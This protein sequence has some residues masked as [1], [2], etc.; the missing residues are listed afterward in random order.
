MGSVRAVDAHCEIHFGGEPEYWNFSDRP[1]MVGVLE[2]PKGAS[3]KPFH[4]YATL[5]LHGLVQG[6]LSHNHG[7]ELYTCAAAGTD[8][9]RMSF[10][11]MA[12]Y[13]I[14]EQIVL[15]AGHMVTP[16]EGP[17]FDGRAFRS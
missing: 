17:I 4:L 16:E 3:Q 12:N 6:P 2:W 11:L 1:D 7:F 10:G 8:D 15:E 14:A 5:G 9:L 13:I